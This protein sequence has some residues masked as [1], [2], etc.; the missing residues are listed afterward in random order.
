MSRNGH[1][2]YEDGSFARPSYYPPGY[3]EDE[4]L[5]VYDQSCDNCC[6]CPCPLEIFDEDSTRLKREKEE[7]RRE[8]GVLRD[9]EPVWCIYWEGRQRGEF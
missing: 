7:M 6:K 2:D 9:G 4:E 5:Y 3:R 8:D 1:Y